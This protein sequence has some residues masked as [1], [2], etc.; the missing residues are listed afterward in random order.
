MAEKGTVSSEAGDLVAPVRT[1]SGRARRLWRRA[2][3][4]ALGLFLLPYA[5]VLLYVVVNPPVT[6]VI[7]WNALGGAGIDKD[8]RD[9]R[10]ISPHLVRA[11][12]MAEDAR[13]CGHHGLDLIELNAAL[14]KAGRGARLRGASTIS[15][16][17]VKNLFLWP[18]RDWV[19]KGLEVPLA[20][21][22]DLVLG[23]KRIMEIYLNVA[24]WGEG[25]YG[26]ETAAQAYFGVSAAELGPGPS[27]RLAAI[28]PAPTSRDAARPG[29][30]TAEAARRIAGRAAQSG[31]YVGCVLD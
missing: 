12:M 3:R 24:E 26:A 2:F 20:L 13:F 22:A 7:L 14:D 28:L 4:V 23:K 29:P 11:V 31:A 1:P 16:Q 25:I 10:D 27:A 15:M 17:T 9:L 8:W 5:L 19:R 30:R 21:W 6:T 18:A